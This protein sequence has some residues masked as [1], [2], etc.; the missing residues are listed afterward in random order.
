MAHL[1]ARLA[2]VAASALALLPLA[3]PVMAQKQILEDRPVTMEALLDRIQIRDFL[4]RYYHDLSVGKAHELADYF[5]EDAVLDVDGMIAKESQD[6]DRQAAS[7]SRRRTIAG[8]EGAIPPRQ[9]AADESHH[10]RGR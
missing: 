5:T 6:G 9:H 2:L 4:T 1:N 10:Q 7:A 3:S 8:G